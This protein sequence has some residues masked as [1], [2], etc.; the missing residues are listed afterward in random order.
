MSEADA[1]RVLKCFTALH[2]SLVVSLLD[3]SA[4][5]T[6]GTGT[7]KRRFVYKSPRQC[8]SECQVQKDEGAIKGRI[9]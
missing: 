6:R 5:Q 1:G 7:L 4:S 3:K 9:Q 2:G 8:P